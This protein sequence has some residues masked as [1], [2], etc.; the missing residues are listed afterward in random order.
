MLNCAIVG[1]TG[2]T[3]VELIKILLRHSYA[4]ISAL[5]TRQEESFPVQSLIPSLPAEIDLRIKKHSFREL[6]RSSDVFFLCLPHTEA[7]KTAEKLRQAG[8]VV[9][10]LSA[11]LRLRDY[12]VYEKWYGVRHETHGLLKEAV[13]G[14]PE[15]FRKKIRNAKMIANPGCYPTGAAL[16]LAPLLKEG[17]IEKDS[18]VIDAKSGVSGA[19]KKLNMATQFY[20][21]DDNFYAYRVGKHQHTPEI[22]QTLSDIAGAA[23]KVTF[24]P[25]LLPISRGIL[26]TMYVRRKKKTSPEIIRQVFEKA[27]HKEPFVRLKADGQFPSLKD[28]QHTNYCDIGCHV[29]PA[30]DRV[31]VVTA[32]D[33]LLKGASGQAVQNLNVC[34]GFPER[35]GLNAW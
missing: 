5:T 11:D 23:V 17:V 35:E 21:L 10:D 22:E 27:Y 6:V 32:I 15:F 20:E 31:I 18:I 12:R 24:V 4:R 16:G 3:G 2:Y 13:Y 33:N 14:L 34:F 26:S 9:I 25:H 19:G 1:A 28:V 8:K 29:D 30:S 7:M